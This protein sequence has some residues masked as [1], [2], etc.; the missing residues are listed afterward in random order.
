MSKGFDPDKFLEDT[1]PGPAS[2]FDPDAFL[3]KT[4]APKPAK[5]TA[6]AA[7]EGFGEGATLG[8]LNNIQAALEKPAFAVMNAVTGQDVAA[9]DYVVSR[10]AY[11]RR[12]AALQKENP[13]AFGV[14]QVAGTMA[15]SVPVARAAQGAT[16][17]ARAIQGAKAGAVYGG[18]QNTAEQEGKS[19]SLDVGERLKGVLLG[20]ATGAGASVGADVAGKAVRSASTSLNTIKNRI[21]QNLRKSAEELAENATGATRVQAEKFSEGSGRKLLDDRIVGFGDDAER[22]AEKANASIRQSEGAIDS[23]LKTLDETGVTVDT[24]KILEKLE[25]KL[26]ELKK[27]PSQS[28]VARKVESIMQDIQASGPDLVTSSAAEQTKRGFNRMAKNWQDPE[29]GQAGK[30]AYRAYRDA[31]EETATRANPAVAETFKDAKK[32]FGQLAPIVDAA[33]KRASQLKQSPLGG[34]LDTAAV[35]GGASTS[36]DP[37]AGGALGLGASVLR[38]KVSPR[39]ASSMAVTFDKM[40]KQLLNDPAIFS[41]AKA[42]P[43]AFRSAVF[44][45]LETRG[46]QSAPVA[47][48]RAAEA[49]PKRGEEKW[50]DD[51]MKKLIESGIEASAAEALMNTTKGRKLLIEASDLKPGSKAM[52]S[53]LARIQTASANGGQ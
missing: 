27:D 18:L 51:G 29:K 34:L 22:I 52:N 37:L 4:S 48:P 36:D 53:V 12:Q 17:T 49:E 45:L 44:G 43:E 32:N 15:S 14:G 42:N 35:I 20:G 40:S 3:S 19:G 47:L 7:L 1:S 6:A 33:E 5:Q 9:D 50:A 24:E 16:M 2:S 39:L 23:S 8:Y 41:A 30:I 46:G 21:G 11:N 10:D 38:R 25:Q 28:D 13:A 31:V 26:V